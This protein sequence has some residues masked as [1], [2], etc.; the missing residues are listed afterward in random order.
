MQNL[1]DIFHPVDEYY[2]PLRGY[3]TILMNY[4]HNEIHR[5]NLISQKWNT[6]PVF[7]SIDEHIRY[8]IP[9]ENFN[10]VCLTFKWSIQVG[11]Y[12]FETNQIT[13][14]INKHLRKELRKQYDSFWHITVVYHKK[15][16]WIFFRTICYILD[17][18]KHRNNVRC[19]INDLES[20]PINEDNLE[21]RDLD[22]RHKTEDHA[23]FKLRNVYVQFCFSTKEWKVTNVFQWHP[24]QITRE[25]CFWPHSEAYMIYNKKTGEE[26]HGAK[27]TKNGKSVFYILHSVE[28]KYYSERMKA[29]IRKFCGIYIE[30]AK[31]IILEYL[32]H[33]WSLF[34]IDFTKGKIKVDDTF[35]RKYAKNN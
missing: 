15:Q 27:W 24:Y 31:N 1:T 21:A 3:G 9:T 29:C 16:L 28:Y 13:Y 35:I 22:L 20:F 8:L 34:D 11:L 10:Q 12:D 17:I 4:H 33:P 6:Y 2:V 7:N 23:F 18:V 25:M 14:L 26:I 5:Y 19:G 30:F 32:I